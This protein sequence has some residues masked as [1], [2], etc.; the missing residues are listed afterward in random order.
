ALPEDN[1]VDVYAQDLGLLGIVEKGRLVGWNVLVGGGMGMSHGNANTF[2]YVGKPIC[3]VPTEEVLE[4]AEAVVKLFRD[5][6]NRSDRK[7]ARIKYVVH[8]WGVERFRDVLAGY[9][10]RPLALPRPVDVT[11]VDLHHGWHP[12]GDGKWFYG[13]SVENGRVKD[14]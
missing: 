4:T 11:G 2:P 1:C 8:A 10:D 9:V 12:Q 13:L 14:D 6:G 5:H 7:R 3:F